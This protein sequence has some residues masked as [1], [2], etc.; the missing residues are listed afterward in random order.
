LVWSK[1]LSKLKDPVP[2][3]NIGSTRNNKTTPSKTPRA[4]N[5]AMSNERNMA[6]DHP[7]TLR[8]RND[9]DCTA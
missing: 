1:S 2:L 9:T 7:L 6:M 3:A 5:R 4:F 8:F